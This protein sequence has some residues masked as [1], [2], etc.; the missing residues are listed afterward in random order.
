MNPRRRVLLVD[1]EDGIRLGLS[2]SLGRHYEI[3]TAADAFEG[4]ACVAHEG[5]FVAIIAD[6]QMPGMDGLTMLRAVARIAPRTVRILFT[7]TLGIKHTVEE[8]GATVGLF[9]AIYKPASTAELLAAL[10][11]AVREYDQDG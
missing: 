5:P 6:F 3:C 1:D 7:G 8:S 2:R 4:R 9:R 10:D 11:E